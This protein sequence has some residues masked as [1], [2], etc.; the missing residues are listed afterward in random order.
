MNQHTA[1]RS[2]TACRQGTTTVEFAMISAVLFPMC[3]AIIE[4]GML[5]WTQGALQST[6]ALVARCA[7]IS[8]PQCTSPQTYAVN[9]ATSWIMSGVISNSDVTITTTTNCPTGSGA[10]GNFKKVV[11]TSEYWASGFLPAPWGSKNLSV[12]A[13]YPL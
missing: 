6:A 8:G 2:F 7:A 4:G 1:M 13:C 5:L 10:S 3:F 9:T 12:T 11:I